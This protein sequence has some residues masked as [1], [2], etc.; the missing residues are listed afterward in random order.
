VNQAFARF[1]R[2]SVFDRPCAREAGRLAAKANEA[3]STDPQR[4]LE[5]VARCRAL[6]PEEPSLVVEEASVL[7]RLGQNEAAATMLDE[8]LHRLENE[9]APWAQAALVRADL[10]IEEG[11]VERA[12]ILW[13]DAIRKEVSPAVDRTA[14]LRR[15][16]AEEPAVN[17]FFKPGDDAVKV[18]ALRNAPQTLPVQYLLGRKLQQL[19]APKDALPYLQA[20]L[21]DEA[22]PSSIRLETK[23]LAIEAA[24]ALGRCGLIGELANE[25]RFDDWNE[26]C[27]FAFP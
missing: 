7:R 23:R 16:G 20:V 9:P 10:A 4:S 27:A 12:R 8:E 19:H 21:A 11:N 3:L 1:R 15:E 24:F 14:R 6:Q 13:G 17:G 22:L 5:L 25:P 2:G 18:L 26:R